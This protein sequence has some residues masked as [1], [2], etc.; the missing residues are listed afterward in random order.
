[1]S[2]PKGGRGYTA[3]YKTTHVRVPVPIK[4]DV[5]KLIDDYRDSLL[6]S[7]EDSASDKSNTLSSN[8]ELVNLPEAIA[9]A[10]GILGQKKSARVSMSKL[11]TSLYDVKVK[12]EDL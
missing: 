6:N 7:N 10:K 12:P 9:L 11:L 5:Q 8:N 1:M 4:E 2:K 3:P